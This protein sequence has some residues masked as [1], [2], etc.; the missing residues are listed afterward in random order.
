MRAT[1]AS[2]GLGFHLSSVGMMVP[3][4]TGGYKKVKELAS[5]PRAQE[6]WRL[7]CA[8]WQPLP[9]FKAYTHVHT[10]ARVHA[11]ARTHST[12]FPPGWPARQQ[13]LCLL[14]VV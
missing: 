8:T 1:R 4:L 5:L 3:A 9:P 7:L 10:H 12:D 2:L 6:G 13:R 14:E 11:G